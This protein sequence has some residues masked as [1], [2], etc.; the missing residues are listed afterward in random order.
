[1]NYKYNLFLNIYSRY[2]TIIYFMNYFL[3]LIKITKLINF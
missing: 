3:I 2:K 1:M